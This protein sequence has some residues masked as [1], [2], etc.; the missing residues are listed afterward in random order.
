MPLDIIQQEIYTGSI[1]I[2]AHSCDCA[3]SLS[4]SA[5]YLATPHYSLH[6]IGSNHI[7]SYF[8]FPIVVL[9]PSFFVFPVTEHPV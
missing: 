7:P 1:N 9:V 4:P 2:R 6:R 3:L 5:P 8:A